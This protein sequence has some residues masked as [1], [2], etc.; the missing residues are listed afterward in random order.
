MK[1]H[2]EE[3]EELALDFIA[4]KPLTELDFLGLRQQ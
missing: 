4:G 3:L 2:Q 1:D